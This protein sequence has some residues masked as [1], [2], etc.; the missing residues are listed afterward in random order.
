[1][2][3]NQNGQE[4]LL[5]YGDALPCYSAATLR[6]CMFNSYIAFQTRL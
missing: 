4:H 6:K 1:M 3:V 5:H 2:V